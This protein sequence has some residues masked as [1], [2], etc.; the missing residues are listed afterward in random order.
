MRAREVMV[1]FT[2]VAGLGLGW[3]AGGWLWNGSRTLP[4]VAC[5][6]IGFLGG[7]LAGLIGHLLG[8]GVWSSQISGTVRML[9]VISGL[10]VQ[11]QAS[12]IPINLVLFTVICFLCLLFVD[13][14]LVIRPFFRPDHLD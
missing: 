4:L 9:L 11:H 14:A 3:V 8:A 13:T 6:Y 10:F 7:G 5:V 2:I 12:P 1:R